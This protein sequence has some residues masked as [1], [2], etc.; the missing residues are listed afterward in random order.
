MLRLRFEEKL[1]TLHAL[2]RTFQQLS[3]RNGALLS[4]RSS[5]LD[6]LYKRY[7]EDKELLIKY[8]AESEALT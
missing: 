6:V 5:E 1:N 4:E 7:D 2:N 8:K 3:V